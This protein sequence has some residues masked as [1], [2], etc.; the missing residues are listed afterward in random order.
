MLLRLCAWVHLQK[1]DVASLLVRSE[2]KAERASFSERH[3]HAARTSLRIRLPGSIVLLLVNLS[4]RSGH[5]SSCIVL[6]R[7]PGR[8]LRV[9][10]QGRTAQAINLLHV[11]G[12]TLHDV[13]LQCL[14]RSLASKA[15]S[16]VHGPSGLPWRSRFRRSA[17]AARHG[18]T[19]AERHRQRTTACLDHTKHLLVV[20]ASNRRTAN[21]PQNQTRRQLRVLLRLCAWVHLQKLDVASLLIRGELKAERASFSERHRHRLLNLFVEAKPQWAW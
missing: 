14:L 9:R 16:L 5:Q 17:W 12:A 10:L 6:R 1:L 2:L 8:R 13:I 15:F 3:R 21:T 19:R 18:P 7:L 20:F 4:H 11:P